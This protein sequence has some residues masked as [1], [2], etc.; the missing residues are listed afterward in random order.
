MS[1]LSSYQKLKKK[2]EVLEEKFWSLREFISKATPSELEMFKKIWHTENSIIQS[3]W[4]GD[5]E[6]KDTSYNGILTLLQEA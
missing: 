5:T 3:W 6:I 2:N 1:K 4:Q